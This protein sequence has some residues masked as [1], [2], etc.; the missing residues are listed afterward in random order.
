MCVLGVV[1]F[2]FVVRLVVDVLR[3]CNWLVLFRVW[4]VAVY[5]FGVVFDWC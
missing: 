2:I 1:C 3:I 5:W 4:F